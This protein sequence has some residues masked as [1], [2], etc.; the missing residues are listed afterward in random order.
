MNEYDKINSVHFLLL[1]N[2]L[3]VINVIERRNSWIIDE[4]KLQHIVTHPSHAL[5][6]T[7]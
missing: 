4:W 6:A 3:Y 7:L 2:N 5:P 1:N